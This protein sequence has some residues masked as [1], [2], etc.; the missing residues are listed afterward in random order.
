MGK[1]TSPN[2]SAKSYDNSSTKQEADMKLTLIDF[3]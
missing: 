2:S 1:T 3:P